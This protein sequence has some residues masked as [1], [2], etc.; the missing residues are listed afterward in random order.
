ME[1]EY[2]KSERQR[3]ALL[4]L[5]FISAE[6]AEVFQTSIQIATRRWVGGIRANLRKCSISPSSPSQ[7]VPGAM[8]TGGISIVINGNRQRLA[9]RPRRLLTAGTAPAPPRERR[10]PRV[11]TEK[12]DAYRWPCPR[13]SSCAGI[14]AG[15]RR[16]QEPGRRQTAA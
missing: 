4:Q 11:C 14:K 8:A 6:I 1:S 13:P 10:N 15:N 9:G 5:V 3:A 16:W 7:Q 2:L 12:G